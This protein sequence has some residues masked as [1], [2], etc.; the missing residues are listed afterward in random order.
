MLRCP[1]DRVRS[2]VAQD[3]GAIDATVSRLVLIELAIGIVVLLLLGVAGRILIRR[4]LRPLDGVERAAAAIAA[5]D[6]GTRAPA[7]D[8]R[9]EIGS[10]A[11]SFN[12]MADNVAGG[13]RR[14]AGI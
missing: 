7:T 10:L 13:V 4:S 3:I 2:P 9:T 14:P 8:P 11:A 5:G 6:L 12:T 1:T